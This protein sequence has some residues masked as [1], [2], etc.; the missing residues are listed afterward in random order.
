V[1]LYSIPT[2]PRLT[3]ADVE[4]S[5]LDV[6]R[7]G[8]DTVSIPVALN[9]SPFFSNLSHFA[10]CLDDTGADALV[11]FNRFYQLDIDLEETRNPP[12]RSVEHATGPAAAADLDRN[13]AWPRARGL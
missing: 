7:A 10:R 9:L 13:P 12:E 8:K 11:L 1:D 5:Y 6:V 2:D 3:A 4:N